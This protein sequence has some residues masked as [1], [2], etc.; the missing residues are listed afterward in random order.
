MADETINILTSLNIETAVFVGHSMGGAVAMQCLKHYPARV[1]GLCLFHATPFAD[2]EEAR[3]ARNATIARIHMG[4]KQEIAETLLKR[5]IPESSWERIGI[6]NI[7]R[8]RAILKQT[9]ESGMIAGH[10]AMLGREDT[11]HVLID[12]PCP[13][14]FLLGKNDPIIAVEAILPLVKL[15][16]TAHISLLSGVAHAGMIEAP[17]PSVALL[18]GFA[19]SVFAATPPAR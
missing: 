14:L 3:T 10:E 19:H 8:L 6:A 7:E 9:P 13:V 17:R 18:L 1:Q 16:Q 5:I 11:Q 2:S 15:P 4:E 12:T